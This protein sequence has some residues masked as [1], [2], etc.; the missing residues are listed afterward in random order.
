MKF[1]GDHY[2][3]TSPVVGGLGTAS[4]WIPT[5][6]QQGDELATLAPLYNTSA[7]AIVE[8]NDTVFDTPS[9]NAWVLATGGVTLSNGQPVFGDNSVIF[10]P[11]GGP[12]SPAVGGSP[13][14]G[15][16]LAGFPGGALGALGALGLLGLGGLALAR[17]KKKG[18]R[19]QPGGRVGNYR[20]NPRRRRRV[21]R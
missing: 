2:V 12:R 6:L 9:I 10:L 3:I 18:G 14:G 4:G 8:G 21:R 13:V 17:R 7:Q 19:R 11:P 15:T 20:L 1:L 5:R 16:F